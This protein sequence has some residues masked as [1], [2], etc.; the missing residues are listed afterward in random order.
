LII[1]AQDD[2]FV[3]PHSLPTASE[4][5][6]SIEF[7]LQAQGGHVGFVDGSLRQPG[8]Y[9]ERR[10]PHWLNQ[11]IDFTRPSGQVVAGR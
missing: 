2:P 9:L 6:P 3:F 5:S 10:I 1:Q 4:M 8:Y 11:W 7:E